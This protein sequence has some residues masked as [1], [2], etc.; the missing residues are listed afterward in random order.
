MSIL[1]IGGAGYIGSHNVW[2]LIERGE[3]VVVLDN[4]STGHEAALHPAAR[5][6]RGDVRS[7]ADLDRVFT[8]NRVEAV[9]HFAAFIQ[10]GESMRDPLRY[11]NNNVYGMQSLL[12]AMVRHGCGRL[13][14]SSSAA[15]YGEPESVP[16][17]ED[18]PC[19]P[20]N[21]YGE[22]KLMMER[23]MHWTEIA[24]GIRWV[25]LRYFNV[26]GALRSGAIGEDHR[27]ES[28]LIPLILQV[29]LGRRGHVAIYGDDYPTPDGTCI[30]D[31]LHV[32]DLTDAHLRALDYLAA[33]GASAICN[34][35]NGQGFSVR[36]MVESARRVTGH[37]IP[38]VVEPRRPGDPPRLVASAEK[39]K[40]LLG[41]RPV[42]GIEAIID[43]AWRWHRLHHEG[44]DE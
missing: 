13:V 2:A 33:G 12:E 42:Y 32:L 10:V 40:E 39:A 19:R 8:E 17:P 16:I 7:A 29:P 24:H 30:R 9:L 20:V 36:E 15:V 1:V 41:W 6:Y 3:S 43:S 11:F 28:H 37:P 18:A 44:Y 22:T 5:L 34:L 14:F 23:M 4:F 21:P 35:G 38:A 31:Y 27:P 25:A 26:G